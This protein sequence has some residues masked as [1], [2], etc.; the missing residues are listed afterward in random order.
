MFGDQGKD[1]CSQEFILHMLGGGSA[2]NLWGGYEK[3]LKYVFCIT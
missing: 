3:Q 1:F 2:W